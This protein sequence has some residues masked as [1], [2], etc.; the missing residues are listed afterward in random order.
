MSA[1]LLQTKAFQFGSSVHSGYLGLC[2]CEVFT[3][4]Y[5]RDGEVTVDGTGVCGFDGIGFGAGFTV[6]VFSLGRIL[7]LNCKLRQKHEESLCANCS[8]LSISAETSR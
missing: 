5:L 4:A 8:S 1:H 6:N 3:D 2:R 7:L